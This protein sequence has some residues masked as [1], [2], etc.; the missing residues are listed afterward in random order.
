[1][2]EPDT[3]ADW[4]DDEPID[5]V[6]LF[7][8]SPATWFALLDELRRRQ[9]PAAV[10]W[11]HDA[12]EEAIRRL[13]DVHQ[14]LPILGLTVSGL[15]G[16]YEKAWAAQNEA[17]E[18]D[19]RPLGET[20]TSRE[21]NSNHR[22]GW[23]ADLDAVLAQEMADAVVNLHLRGATDSHIST[24]LLIPAD[25]PARIVEAARLS[26]K[27]QAV[28]R[29][30][31]EGASL[32]G[33]AKATGVPATSALR[34]LRQIDEAPHGAKERV[35]AN[36]RARAIVRLRER[37]GLTYKE[38]ADRLGCSMDTVKNVLRRKRRPRYGKGK[39]PAE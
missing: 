1:V 11:F 31:L 37:E 3:T 26:P 7:M 30:H 16:I 21:R 38:I 36:A 12:C 24:I 9:E 27:A 25:W 2:G 17:V 23:R 5:W 10:A 13:T 14:H 32:A 8:L 20:E 19:D 35:D 18:H 22:A 29:A 6:R 34:I 39:G 33:I 28:V 4:P 15:A